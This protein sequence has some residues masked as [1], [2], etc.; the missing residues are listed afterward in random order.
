MTPEVIAT[1]KLHP[2]ISRLARMTTSLEVFIS[3]S[4]CEVCAPIS[5]NKLDWLVKGKA[6]S[7]TVSAR[8]MA[9][10][11]P[12]V[13]TATNWTG[14]CATPLMFA[15]G[16]VT[17]DAVVIDFVTGM[18]ATSSPSA[19]YRALAGHRPNAG[20]SRSSSHA[21]T[22]SCTSPPSPFMSGTE[23]LV[24]IAD[25]ATWTKVTPITPGMSRSRGDDRLRYRANVIA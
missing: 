24:C 4:N 7:S 20:V 21:A 9:A 17:V 13:A 6:A 11:D 19:T 15:L 14:S 2:A 22:P 5:P 18:K 1:A 10:G 23:A 12:S 3:P 8:A 25:G 16:H